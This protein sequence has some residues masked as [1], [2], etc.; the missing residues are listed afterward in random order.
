[1]QEFRGSIAQPART[2]VNTSPTPSRALTHDSGP[3]WIA[4]PSTWSPFS[5]FSM[6][7]YPG[8]TQMILRQ[9]L[10]QRRRH[11]QQ[12]AALTPN[13]ISS[14]PGSVLNPA[15]S[16]DIP[17]ASHGCSSRVDRV[18]VTARRSPNCALAT[19]D[20]RRQ[21]TSRSFGRSS[22]R[23]QMAEAFRGDLRR[24]RL[25]AGARARV[26]MPSAFTRKPFR[27]RRRRRRGPPPRRRTDR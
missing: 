11:Q 25:R 3:S 12:L 21:T 22:Q 17:T 4:T 7:V 6:P 27:R 10:H 15:D 23:T 24:S 9:P 18:A 14:H 26:R 1:M 16:T 2:P 13:E 19:T 5:S 20:G 8:A